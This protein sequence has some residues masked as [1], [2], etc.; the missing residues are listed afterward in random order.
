MIVQCFILITLLAM[1]DF[2]DKLNKEL[3]VVYANYLEIQEKGTEQVDW[4]H[5]ALRHGYELPLLMV[6]TGD[7]DS[8]EQLGFRKP[9]PEAKGLYRGIAHLRDL[10][11]LAGDARVKLIKYEHIDTGDFT[12]RKLDPRIS[13]LLEQ[14][15]QGRAIFAEPTGSEPPVAVEYI[16][17]LI[18]FKGSADT[19]IALGCKIGTIVGNMAS[20]S[21]PIDRLEEVIAHPNVLRVETNRRYSPDLDESIKEI[22]ADSLRNGSPPFGGEGKYTGKDVIVGIIDFGFQY[23]HKAFRDPADPS[24]SRIL[25][26]YDQSLTAEASDTAPL[27][28][29]GDPMI[30][31]EY[32]KAKIEAA[33]AAADPKTVVRH[34][35]D[36]HG[37]HVAGIAA[38]NGA[39]AGNCH[40][41]FHYIGVAPEADLILVYLSSGANRLGESN[42]LIDAISYIRRKAEALSKPVVINMS[43]GDNLGAHDGSS[44]VEEM[45]DLMLLIYNPPLHDAKGFSIVKSAGNLG[46]AEKHAQGEVPASN[47]A[48][49]LEL[50]FKVIP[51][52]SESNRT[53]IEFD[54]WYADAHS[55]DIEITPPGNN[56]TGTNSA[57]PGN[58]VNF[59]E[60][61]NDSDVRIESRLDQGNGKKQIYVRIRPNGDTHNLPGEWVVKLKNAAA[62]PVPFDAWIERDQL[63]SFTT[64]ETNENTISIPGTAK[65]VITVANYWGKGKDK[66]KL[67]ASSSRGVPGAAPVKPEI[68]A[69]GAEIIAARHDAK[70]GSCCDC[71]YDF[72]TAKTGTSM[73]APHVAGAI[74]LMLEKNPDISHDE[75]KQALMDSA[76]EDSFTGAVPNHR[77]GRGKLDVTAA[78]EEIST[79]T[80]ALVSPPPARV[81]P[82]P[83]HFSQPFFAAD[84]PLGRF[85]AT[86]AGRALHQLMLKHYDEVRDLVN[87][88]KRVAAVW[89]RNKGPLLTHHVIRAAMLPEAPLPDT[90]EGLAVATLLDNIAAALM[91]HGG[92]DLREALRQALP[93]AEKLPG[94]NFHEAVA[95]FEE[96]SLVE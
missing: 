88:N 31:V 66:G 1:S 43:L 53:W 48:T 15:L 3:Q 64:F 96:E 86:P 59:T 72:Y 5:P 78:L 92:Q 76:H 7:A 19:L 45:I 93:L 2:W 27:D 57:A 69:P 63:A 84:S 52:W 95:L 46:N 68:A 77:F 71:C 18:K 83:R 42:N 85:V 35:P 28:V 41:A 22:K 34:E 87:E 33:I 32:D 20:V 39:Q 62:A 40:G 38:G 55:L 61:T 82:S 29:L 6:Y 10:E 73:A 58:I 49:P 26:L 56:I 8:L 47:T 9:V 94:K 50:K 30:G 91:E 70:A 13:D 14:R 89:Q 60:D 4:I 11:R 65:E 79:G 37:T 51:P 81:V 16:G 36:S 90:L 25:F 23:A 44:L 74:A 17:A 75:I 67:V 80:R 54:I 12:R 24:K 21:I